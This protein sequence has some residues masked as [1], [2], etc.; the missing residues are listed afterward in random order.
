MIKISKMADY[1]VV[2]LAYL[3][4]NQ[5]SLHSASMISLYV[6]L[7]EPTVSK[8]LKLLNKSD[9]VSSVRGA[10][11]GYK[12]TQSA[13]H[14]SLADI[15]IAIEGPIA[16]TSC[17]EASNDS[18]ALSKNCGVNGRW[19]GVSLAIE[20]ALDNVSLRSMMTPPKQIKQMESRA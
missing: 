14:I 9:L 15:I 12:I 11:G 17:V 16:L 18:C 7:P 20:T 4:A 5:E 2:V 10:S 3:A 13:E 1:A 6:F 19:N 8:V